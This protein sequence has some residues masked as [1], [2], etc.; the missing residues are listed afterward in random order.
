LLSIAVA[1]RQHRATVNGYLIPIVLN[2]FAE[3]RT[4]AFFEAQEY[5]V[6]D[7][8]REHK[9]DLGVRGLPK[10]HLLTIHDA[11]PDP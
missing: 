11:P 7:L 8:A 5:I 2:A 3:T 6:N 9:A 10:H 4:A 1:I